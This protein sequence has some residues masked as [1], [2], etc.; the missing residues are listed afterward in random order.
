MGIHDP[1]DKKLN[2]INDYADY[3]KLYLE[4]KNMNKN[5]FENCIDIFID[6]KKI[7]FDYKYQIKRQKKLKLNLYL[8]NFNKYKWDVL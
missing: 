8:K 1:E 7:K 4:A 3:A 5:I 6:N 2:T